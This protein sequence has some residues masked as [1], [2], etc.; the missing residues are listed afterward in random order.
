MGV[1]NYVLAIGVEGVVIDLSLIAPI[2]GTQDRLEIIRQ[3]PF[4]LGEDGVGLGQLAEGNV[5]HIVPVKRE[6]GQGV[7]GRV[8]AIYRHGEGAHHQFMLAKMAR[9]PKLF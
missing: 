9:S 7:G 4:V 3:G 1:E 5:G 6:I 8:V 2:A